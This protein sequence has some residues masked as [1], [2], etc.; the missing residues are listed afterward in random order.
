MSCS[1]DLWRMKYMTLFTLENAVLRG[2]LA[3]FYP[4]LGKK[5]P[6]KGGLF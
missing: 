5:K 1:L 2:I 6:P 3:A 4:D